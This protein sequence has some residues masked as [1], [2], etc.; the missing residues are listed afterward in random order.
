MK[1]YNFPVYG[2]QGGGLARNVEG[3]FIFVEKPDCPGLSVGDEVPEQWDIIPANQLA[4][5]SE[6]FARSTDEFFDTAFD[7]V[8][9]GNIPISALGRFFPQTA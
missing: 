4:K 1:H 9:D 3:K 8:K 7:E 6:E 2:T 5:D